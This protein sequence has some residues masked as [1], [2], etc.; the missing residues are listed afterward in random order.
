[1]WHR[2][3]PRE[4]QEQSREDGSESYLDIYQ[5][6]DG[7]SLPKLGYK[8]R[9]IGNISLQSPCKSPVQKDHQVLSCK[10]EYGVHL[11]TAF[12]KM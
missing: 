10:G 12:S 1:M 9:A 4:P 3:E 11:M 2:D 8:R 7:A 5:A 6:P